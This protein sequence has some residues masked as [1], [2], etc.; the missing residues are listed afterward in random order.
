M[1]VQ[2]TIDPD[3]EFA[4]RRLYK[5]GICIGI[6]TFDPNVDDKLLGS[7]V[8]ITKYPVRILRCKTLE[9]ASVAQDEADSGIVSKSGPRSLLNAFVLC[10]KVLYANRTNVAV[11][12]LSVAF[13]VLLMAFLLVFGK[14]TAIPSIYVVLYQLFWMVPVYLISKF[15]V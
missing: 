13:S 9:E 11:K 2:Y 15:Y 5:A 1:Y 8:K 12:I 7:K 6:K 3:F 14:I 10:S 4:L